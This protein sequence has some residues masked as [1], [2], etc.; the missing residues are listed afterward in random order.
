MKNYILHCYDK[1]NIK[2]ISFLLNNTS[3]KYIEQHP[4]ILNLNVN[5][6]M[7]IDIFVDITG[8]RSINTCSNT[9]NEGHR[10]DGPKGTNINSLN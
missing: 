8:K 3:F 7:L 2:R 5:V 6:Y 9:S 1:L 4:I 10:I